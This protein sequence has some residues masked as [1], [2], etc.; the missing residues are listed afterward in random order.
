MEREKSLSSFRIRA[1]AVAAEF[2]GAGAAVGL[3]EKLALKVSL[4]EAI[5]LGAASG[6]LISSAVER[7]VKKKALQDLQ[8]EKLNPWK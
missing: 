4:E 2:V 5:A 7:K 6:I 1:Q 3:F 8:K